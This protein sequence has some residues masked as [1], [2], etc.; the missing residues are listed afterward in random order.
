MGSGDKR[1]FGHPPKLSRR[2]ARWWSNS[3][4]RC[5][6]VELQDH[7]F[8]DVGAKVRNVARSYSNRFSKHSLACLALESVR[9]D[10]VDVDAEEVA[11]CEPKADLV[12]Q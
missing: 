1:V 11:K 9:R 7:C 10:H 2:A 4:P 8:D 3:P 5:L 12:K 6:M